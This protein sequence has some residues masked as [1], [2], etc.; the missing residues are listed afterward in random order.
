MTEFRKG[1]HQFNG[2]TQQRRQT[3]SAS[4]NTYRTP[5]AHL[6]LV[7]FT[8]RSAVLSSCRTHLPN[9]C[10]PRHLDGLAR[11]DAIWQRTT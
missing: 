7:E 5:R 6:G 9:C 3:S 8:G 11:Y 2:T 10:L 4:P 1:L